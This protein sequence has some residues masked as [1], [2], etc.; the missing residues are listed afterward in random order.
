M[1]KIAN[2]IKEDIHRFGFILCCVVA[3]IITIA[4]SV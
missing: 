2:F 3:M 1:T 4:V